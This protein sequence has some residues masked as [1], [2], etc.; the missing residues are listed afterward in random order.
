M[1]ENA[2]LRDERDAANLEL[3]KGFIGKLLQD[4]AQLQHKRRGSKRS[5]R[6]GPL[7]LDKPS[8]VEG[9]VEDLELHLSQASVEDAPV[10]PGS[11]IQ[12]VEHLTISSIIKL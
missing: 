11:S 6:D 3:D 5:R 1:P 7:G 4:V 12:Q 2:R 10:P 8:R 9:E